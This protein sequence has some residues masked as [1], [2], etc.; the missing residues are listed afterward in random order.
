VRQQRVDHAGVE[1][2]PGVIDALLAHLDESTTRLD[3]EA[4][5]AQG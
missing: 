4:Q 2:G 5:R 3:M 1:L